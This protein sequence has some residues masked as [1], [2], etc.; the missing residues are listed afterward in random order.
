MDCNKYKLFCGIFAKN[1]THFFAC[2]SARD[3]E[4]SE[5]AVCMCIPLHYFYVPTYIYVNA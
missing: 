2:K 1:K 5:W 3:R 4:S